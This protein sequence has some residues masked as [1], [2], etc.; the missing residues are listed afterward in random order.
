MLTRGRCDCSRFISPHVDMHQAAGTHAWI[1]FAYSD[2]KGAYMTVYLAPRLQQA[3]EAGVRLEQPVPDHRSDWVW[4]PA[5]KD[6]F[7]GQAYPYAR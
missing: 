5:A 1:S 7:K 4:H 3:W 2:D 6:K